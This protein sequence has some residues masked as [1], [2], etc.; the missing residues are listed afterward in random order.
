MVIIFRALR[1]VI[2]GVI[3]AEP[4]MIQSVPGGRKLGSGDGKEKDECSRQG[5]ASVEGQRKVRGE[6]PGPKCRWA[7][8]TRP[9]SY[10]DSGTLDGKLR[11]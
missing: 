3:F 5:K 6:Q 2:T 8:K 10:C 1:E 9:A 7:V 4:G 11:G